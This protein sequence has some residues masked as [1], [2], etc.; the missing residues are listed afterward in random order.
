MLIYGVIATILIG[1][2]GLISWYI[3]RQ[4][5]INKLNIL[6]YG[7]PKEKGIV[8]TRQGVSVYTSE[9]TYEDLNKELIEEWIDELFL[10]WREVFDKENIIVSD[11][12]LD[13]CLKGINIFLIDE[14]YL[15]YKTSKETIKFAGLS[16]PTTRLIYITTISKN[17][18]NISRVKSLIRH[19]CSH[20][21]VISCR[22]PL[23]SEEESHKYFINVG[24]EGG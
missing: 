24:L 22:S 18:D 21:I 13:K 14:P 6:T 3:Y 16:F 12:Y 11:E 2:I 5:K 9:L 1:L 19:E 20:F 4:I 8:A 7:F 17:L 15:Y 10:F 23:I